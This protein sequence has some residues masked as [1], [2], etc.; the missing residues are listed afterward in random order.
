MHFQNSNM[1]PP[2][3]V[4]DDESD[5]DEELELTDEAGTSAEQGGDAPSTPDRSGASKRKRGEVA[6]PGAVLDETEIARRRRRRQARAFHKRRKSLTRMP[7]AGAVQNHQYISDM[8][9]TIIKM[10]SENVSMHGRD[11]GMLCVLMHAAIWFSG[12]GSMIENQCEE[13]LVTASDRPHG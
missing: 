10:S 2:P 7:S 12:A 9:S 8:Y 6:S 13:L 4:S 3:S 1:A 11:V 5:R